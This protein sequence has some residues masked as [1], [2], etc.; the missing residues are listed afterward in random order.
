VSVAGLGLLDSVL[1]SAGDGDPRTLRAISEVGRW[2]GYGIGNMINIFNPELVV[3]GG[4][5]QAL[6][7]YLESAV[8]EGAGLRALDA[9]RKVA[10]IASSGLGSDATLIGAA[11]LAL[12]DL[13]ADPAATAGRSVR[14][15]PPVEG[16]SGA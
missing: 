9:P 4:F 3:L 6:F 1:T 11:E 15:Q 10:T 8:D 2:L 7:P 14:E 13:I 16:K 5:Y 12:S